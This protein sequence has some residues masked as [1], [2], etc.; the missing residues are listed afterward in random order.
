MLFEPSK[1]HVFGREVAGVLADADSAQPSVAEG[2]FDGSDG[3]A[4]LLQIVT[5]DMGRG[6]S[7]LQATFDRFHDILC[8]FLARGIGLPSLH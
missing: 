3:I 7:A 5:N 6:G 1:H 8:F 4:S 2:E